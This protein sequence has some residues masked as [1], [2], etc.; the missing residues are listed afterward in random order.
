MHSQKTTY[1]N[2]RIDFGKLNILLFNS[3]LAPMQS[4]VF[5]SF[6]HHRE[7]SLIM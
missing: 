3:I 4:S 2:I 1:G 6:N 7:L 5:S